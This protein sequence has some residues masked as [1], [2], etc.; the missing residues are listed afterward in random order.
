MTIVQSQIEINPVKEKDIN[1]VKNPTGAKF[2]IPYRDWKIKDKKSEV[3][4]VPIEYCKFRLENGRIKHQILSHEKIKGTLDR[5][6]DDTQKIISDYISKSDPKKNQ[7]LKKLLAKD[8]QSEPAIM[9]ADGFLIN[10]NRR[11]WAFHELSKEYPNERYNRLKVVILPGSESPERPTVKDI[12]ILENRYQVYRD[13]KSEYS[14]MNK[15]L[16][17]YSYFK[18]DIPLEELLKDDPTYGDADPKKFKQNLKKF[19]LEFFEPIKLMEEFLEENNVKGD[20]NRISNRWM[21]FEELGKNLT[22]KF[23]NDKFLVEHNIE[24]NE[25][26]VI[27]NAAFNLIKIKETSELG[28]GDNRFLIRQLPKWIKNQKN[29]V[30]KIGKLEDVDPNITDPDERD[31]K[32]HDEK[33]EQVLNIIKKIQNL[34]TRA[35]DQEDPINRLNEALQ[36]LN[37]EDLYLEQIDQMKIPDVEKA[38]KICQEIE[39]RNN[40]IKRNFYDIQK[41]VKDNKKKIKEKWN[42]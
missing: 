12:A 16:T 25:I 8:G 18:A 20:Y 40:E 15:A 1:S 23:E 33:E 5:D 29:D 35:K 7:D 30:L 14:K 24:K 31:A 38:F 6:S 28:V 32:W 13:G 34:T 2:V 21:S 27:K 19:T 3:Y 9:T 17:Y 37:H 22:S 39:T 4:E 26:G 36:K 42:S 11:K 10:G 41:G